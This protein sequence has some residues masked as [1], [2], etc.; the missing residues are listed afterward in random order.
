M[1]SESPLPC[2]IDHLSTEVL[3]LIFMLI[4]MYRR[5][6]SP[7]SP[8]PPSLPQAIAL[9]HVSRRFRRAMLHSTHWLAF[10]ST[11][12][13]SL[14]GTANSRGMLL[15]QRTDR[16]RGL[17][18][19]LLDDPAVV[20]CL[21]RKTDWVLPYAPRI[22]EVFA[23]RIPN[24]FGNAKKIV[25]SHLPMEFLLAGLWHNVVELKIEPREIDLTTIALAFP[26]V[27]Y[28]HLKL[29][30]HVVGS[31]HTLQ[32][33]VHL[34]LSPNGNPHITGTRSLFPLGSAK[35]LTYLEFPSLIPGAFH[36]L[37]EFD[38][39][40]LTNL[41][42][43]RIPDSSLST[44]LVPRVSS[45]LL[46]LVVE[47]EDG[48]NFSFAHPCLSSL[49]S[50]SIT[51][52][53]AAFACKNGFTGMNN[54]SME[55]LE[56]L[57]GLLPSLQDLVL[58]QYGFVSDRVGCLARLRQLKSLVYGQEHPIASISGDDPEVV[59]ERVFGHKP[60]PKITFFRN[61]LKLRPKPRFPR[62]PEPG[63]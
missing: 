58:L 44:I 26:N 23:E 42:H 45:N 16:Q 63:S 59:L 25:A 62:F 34:E 52:I 61:S 10:E 27:G 36:D 15:K 11:F 20:Q 43:L 8:D 53:P 55:L 35:S 38:I 4:P 39:S 33:L 49:Q 30:N 31:I 14:S 21:S 3:D 41:R 46:S 12:L 29:Y 40:S 7:P 47:L 13:K 19:A 60:K 9:M 2:Y 22:T 28:L 57:T 50:L 1:S 24:F 6:P 32:R 37:N 48:Q 17:L 18:D 54:R 51:I 5:V 56:S